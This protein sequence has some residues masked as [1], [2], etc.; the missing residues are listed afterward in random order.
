MNLIEATLSRPA[1]VLLILGAGLCALPALAISKAELSAAQARHRAEVAVCNSGQSNQD[2]PTCLR[3]AGAALAEARRGNLDE[4][5][6]DLRTN[7]LK[8]CEPLPDAERQACIARMNGAGTSSG[9][10]ATGG[11]YRELVVRETVQ[12][13]APEPAALKR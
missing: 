4:G 11:I 9:T 5:G 8:R 7:Q 13:V 2:R 6:A 1:R 3:E 10:A 12:P